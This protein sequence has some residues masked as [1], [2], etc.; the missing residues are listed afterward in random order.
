ME[1]LLDKSDDELSPF[2]EEEMAE[3]DRRKASAPTSES[4][5]T[6][7]TTEQFDG[8]LDTL[9]SEHRSAEQ[10][11]YMTRFALLGLTGSMDAYLV[12]CRQEVSLLMAVERLT[13]IRRDM[14]VEPVAAEIGDTHAR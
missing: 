5:K 2:D 4:E 7:L 13:E 8:L 3:I 1:K 9:R 11:V 12:A 10:T 6:R 14:P